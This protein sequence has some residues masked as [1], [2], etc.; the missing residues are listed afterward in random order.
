[1]SCVPA[2]PGSACVQTVYFVDGNGV[3]QQAD[4]IIDLTGEFLKVKNFRKA[5]AGFNKEFLPGSEEYDNFM[6]DLAFQA[7]YRNKVSEVKGEVE[8][9]GGNQVRRARSAAA[10]NGTT[11]VWDGTTAGGGYY[12]PAED[13]GNATPQAAAEPNPNNEASKDT[14]DQSE[15]TG[16]DASQNISFT[17]KFNQRDKFFS[18]QYPIDANYGSSQDSVVIDMYEYRAPQK[19][20]LFSDGI[21]TGSSAATTIFDGL[22]RNS[23]IKNLKGTVRLPIPNNLS[24]TQDVSWG[25]GRANALEAAAFYGGMGV[26]DKA[27]QGDFIGALQTL[28]KGGMDFIK[29]IGEGKL[30]TGTDMNLILSSFITQQVLGKIGINVDSG[31]LITRAT[32]SRINSNLELLFSAPE[33]RSFNFTFEFAP[34]SSIEASTVRKIQRFFKQGMS[35][36]RNNDQLLFLGS[37]NVFRIRYMNGRNQIQGLNAHKICALVSCGIDFTPDNIYQAYEDDKAVSQ[38]ISSTMTLGFQELTPIFN[39]DYEPGSN[40]QNG[41]ETDS[42]V[43]DANITITDES[44][45]F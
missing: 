43:I 31:S 11:D 30:G 9:V 37:P 18:G 44:V 17:N 4:I 14:V 7:Q 10:V 22:G 36:Q 12:N 34:N 39:Q 5:G 16:Q 15:K 40:Q 2:V 8:R 25:P 41:T 21:L 45:G 32:G 1:M 28:G 27:I 23:N 33:L 6:K 19:D 42:S 26:A 38:P 24:S 20:L 29:Q 35:P 13:P 3:K